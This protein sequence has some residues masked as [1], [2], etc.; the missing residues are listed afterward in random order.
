[1]GTRK[2]LIIRLSI[3]IFVFVAFI[4]MVV[5]V[6]AVTQNRVKSGVSISYV[7][8]DVDGKVEATYTIGSETKYL[9][10]SDGTGTSINFHAGEDAEDVSLVFPTEEML[11]TST[12]SSIVLRYMFTN[13]GH[14]V[15]TAI[16]GITDLDAYN[17]TLEY[18]LDGV[19]YQSNQYALVVK[20]TEI[21]NLYI[22]ISVNDIADIA[23]ING[24]IIWV[25]EN[26][27]PVGEEANIPVTNCSYTLLEDGTYQANCDS[28]TTL[29]ANTLVVPSSVGTISVSKFYLD[30]SADAE[31]IIISEGVNTLEMGYCSGST[32]KS[33]SI[34]ASVTNIVGLQTAGL[35][36]FYGCETL[37]E[38]KV[39]E[40][41]EYYHVEGNCLIDTNNKILLAGAKNCEIPMKGSVTSIATAAFY[42][43]GQEYFYIP[44]AIESVEYDDGPPV[45]PLNDKPAKIF[46]ETK[47]K[48]APEGINFELWGEEYLDYNY[49]F[50]YEEYLICKNNPDFD[51]EK[52]SEG[53]LVV[54]EYLGSET[55]ITIPYGA[56]EIGEGFLFEN[57][58]ITEV[59][60]PE[61]VTTINAKAF[62]TSALEMIFIPETVETMPSGDA[63]F[64][65]MMVFCEAESKP[66]GW[67]CNANSSLFLYGYSYQQYL[68]E[69]ENIK[70]LAENNPDFEFSGSIVNA[71]NGTESVLVIP[72]GVTSIANGVF[73]DNKNLVSVRLP[74]TMNKIGDNA[75]YDCTN[76]ESI[77]IPQGVTSIG[78]SA[79]RGCSS[80]EVIEVSP[81]NQNFASEGNC[82][83]N[84]TKTK[85]IA[86]SK[87]SV[88]PSS[89]TTINANAFYGA[90]IRSIEIPSSV[91]SI[92]ANAFTDCVGLTTITIPT[93]IKTLSASTF[94]G[95]T[96]L[97]SF[98]IPDS[99]TSIKNNV[100]YNC[101]SLTEVLIPSSVTSIGSKVWSGCAA[102][103]KIEVDSANTKYASEGNCLLNKAKTELIVG[104]K[105]SVIP[106]TVQTI[107]SNAF[108][109][110][111]GLTSITFSSGV[112][113]LE[114]N[115]FYGCT[116][117]TSLTI[118][119]SITAIYAYAFSGCTNLT[120]VTFAVTTNWFTAS[121]KNAEE[122]TDLE[123]AT[124]ANATLAATELTTNSVN[125]YWKRGA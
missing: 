45:F 2:K 82:L 68:T 11:L 97:V 103:T 118:T 83:L 56:V 13:T 57:E 37:E 74:E 49:V 53:N 50:T 52:S 26:Y 61:T 46:F 94:Q 55:E 115:A 63:T 91:T 84:K 24:E 119:S 108:Y 109:N 66:S 12:H 113:T 81:D 96:N 30:S 70:Y 6:L 58:T 1:M 111:T 88:I 121:S 101:S 5:A 86:G 98:T 34:P 71:Y 64:T 92:G 10:R 19:N 32:I 87:M 123:S 15:Y 122:G 104:C 114:N 90:G 93:G 33:V 112:T 116:G 85:L 47:K 28:T 35:C 80:L 120:S 31:N 117:L 105:T 23:S 124:L 44:A 41:N 40:G 110:C 8:I 62:H 54:T 21:S 39:A 42:R 99:V 43:R 72:L 95:C 25:L 75:F 73:R 22:R 107:K 17:M 16:M 27:E 38:I 65:N 76:L 48:D 29:T 20:N 7:P 4:P 69:K 78:G 51:F 100:F 60:I 89:V 3:V 59:V 9:Q 14:N 102:L 106:S 125:L 67:K 79:F 36:Y 77:Y 18:S